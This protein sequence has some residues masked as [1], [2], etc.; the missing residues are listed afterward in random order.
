MGIMTWGQMRMQL[1]TAAPG[2]SADLLDEYLNTR[3]EQVLEA[4]D[5]QGIVAHATVETQAAYQ[6]TT[7][8]A[9]FTV[10]NAT[11]TGVSTAWTAA[12]IGQKMYR[13]GDVPIYIVTAVNSTTS[14]TLD[15]VY[16]GVDGDAVGTVHGTSPYV[17]MQNVYILPNDCATIISFLDPVT[18][19]PMNRLTKDE[20]D[21][22]AGTR[23]LIDDPTNYALYDDSTETSPPVLHQIEF[24]PPPRFAK[25]YP[26][27]YRRSVLAF[28][29][30][31]T[32][33]YPLP[34][35]SS[36]VLLHGCRADIARYL[37]AEDPKLASVY[38]GQATQYEAL[39]GVELARLLRVEHSQRRKKMP[40]KMADRFTRHRLERAS[41]NYNNYWG[42]GQGGPN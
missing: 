20:M 1:Q 37:A 28:D 21:L 29:G 36:T 24:Y 2:V 14:L 40:M 19:W 17:F 35:I 33:G 34:F 8:T 27:E 31:N 7:D 39:F 15:R 32:Q 22:S 5:W 11:V 9:T 4:T 16:E 12:L 13:P 3:Y 18:G 30:G 26:L 25:G 38:L 42:H 23:T 10:G 6:S 41:R